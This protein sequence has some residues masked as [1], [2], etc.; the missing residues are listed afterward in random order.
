MSTTSNDQTQGSQEPTP[1]L[2]RTSLV[3]SPVEVEMEQLH[4]LNDNDSLIDNKEIQHPDDEPMDS[5][6]ITESLK[7]FLQTYVGV[8]WEEYR[9]CLCKGHIAT[10]ADLLDLGQTPPTELCNLLGRE[11]YTNNIPLIIRIIVLNEYCVGTL[12]L[13]VNNPNVLHN[14]EIEDFQRSAF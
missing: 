3:Y 2:Q 1:E 9:T 11:L 14:L 4:T 12:N 13:M 6:R 5:N 7:T 8:N 10:L